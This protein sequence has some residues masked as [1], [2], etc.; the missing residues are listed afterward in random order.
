MTSGP[1]LAR[2]DRNSTFIS[3]LGKIWARSVK[4][5]L[6]ACPIK[7]SPGPNELSAYLGYVFALLSHRGICADFSSSIFSLYSDIF[8]STVASSYF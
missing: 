1:D 6:N 8:F 4:N 7:S 2:T 3:D 5:G